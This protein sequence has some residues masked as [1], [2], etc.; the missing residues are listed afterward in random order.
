M[1]VLENEV[2]KTHIEVATLKARNVTLEREISEKEKLCAQLN[3]KCT[4]LEQVRKKAVCKTL[5]IFGVG[6]IIYDSMYITY[7]VVLKCCLQT[8]KDNSDTIKDLSTS[9]QITKKEKV[10]Q[11]YFN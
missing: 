10:W 3:S 2:Q 7:K 9:L 8:I 1:N 6:I 4:Y 11:H 5:H